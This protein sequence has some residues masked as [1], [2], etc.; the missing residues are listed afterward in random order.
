MVTFSVHTNNTAEGRSENKWLFSL[1]LANHSTPA[2]VD[3]DLLVP[4][5]SHQANDSDNNEPIFSV[6]VRCGG[7]ALQSGHENAIK[8]R[9]DEGPMRLHWINEF[10]RMHFLAL[11]SLLTLHSVGRERSSMQMGLST[12]NSVSGS[13]N[14]CARLHHSSSP[15]LLIRTVK[16]PW[17]RRPKP[18]AHIPNL[19]APQKVKV[20]TSGRKKIQTRWFIRA[21]VEAVVK[22][23]KQW[24]LVRSESCDLRRFMPHPWR[25]AIATWI[26]FSK[27]TSFGLSALQL[28]KDRIQRRATMRSLCSAA[29]LCLPLR[30]PSSPPTVHSITQLRIPMDYHPTQILT[31]HTYKLGDTSGGKTEAE[32]GWGSRMAVR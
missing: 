16:Y 13:I 22:T 2:W 24:V 6:P 32:V 5:R 3:A 18:A 19:R 14:R 21:Y 15:I 28:Q 20:R 1:E 17:Y 12:P 29:V 30:Q 23:A 10:V 31:G 4:G 25:R 26:L 11:P 27:T 8:V 9:L 7:Y